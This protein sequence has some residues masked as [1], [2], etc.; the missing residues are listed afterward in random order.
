M[1]KLSAVVTLSP[2]KGSATDKDVRAR[3]L[4]ELY[5][6]CKGAPPSR[7]ARISIRGPEGEV[8]L[9]FASFIKEGK[10]AKE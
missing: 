7:V 2:E 3:S 1:A 4:E 5:A 10:R 6:V 8:R 9:N